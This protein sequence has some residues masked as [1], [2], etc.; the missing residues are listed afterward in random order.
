VLFVGTPCQIAGLLAFL[1]GDKANLI[2]VDFICHGVPSPKVFRK[3]LEN[4]EKE[5]GVHLTDINFR[6]KRRGWLN[7]TVVG[8]SSDNKHVILKG[9][10]NSY[11]NAFVVGTF[12]RKSCYQ[13]PVIGLPRFGNITIAD[14]WG[15]KADS[16]ISQQEIDKGV[17][18]LMVNDPTM[19]KM[20]FEGLAER[21][22]FVE[23]E[24]SDAQKGNSPMCTP[25]KEP[26]N[27]T[28]FFADLNRHPYP[29]LADKYL[30]PKLKRR[31]DQLIKENCSAGFINNL[32][33]LQNA[34]RK[35]K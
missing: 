24:F 16:V 22:F 32:R 20:V 9:V 8:S 34:L 3:Y 15:I 12:L 10:K 17:S 26:A 25:S 4:I 18:L 21:L 6:D 28:D 11:Y 33:K 19:K 13:C 23:R 14:F 27:R 5:S 35:T 30:K 2:T 7:N 1:G 31:L 29:T